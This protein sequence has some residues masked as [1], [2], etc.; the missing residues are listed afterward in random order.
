MVELIYLISLLLKEQSKNSVFNFFKMWQVLDFKSNKT[1]KLKFF[2]LLVAFTTCY[3]GEVNAQASRGG[4]FDFA[5]QVVENDYAG[6][7][8]KVTDKNRAEYEKLKTSL[9][10]AI[11]KGKDED[12][13]IGRYISWFNDGH[14]HYPTSSVNKGKSYNYTSDM[15]SKK[16]DVHT[17]MIRVP[18]FDA[19]K[20]SA[21][22]EMVEQYKKS[23]CEN[24]V[25]DIRS[26]GGGQ[27][28]T[29]D[30]LLALIYTHKGVV[31]GVEWLSTKNNINS[32]KNI[33]SKI[34]DERVRKYYNR[35]CERLELHVGEFVDNSQSTQEIVCDEIP[36]LPR[37]VAIVIDGNVVS[38]G[39][40]FVLNAK[41][42]S[43][44]VTVYGKDNTMGVL[45]FSN[46]VQVN[47]PNS[48][49][50]LY[51][52][53]SRS[54]RLPDRGIDEK[55][56]APDVRIT[57][58]NPKTVGSEIDPWITWISNDMMTGKSE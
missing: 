25:I 3:L 29:F 35:I 34:D 30:S 42:C 45:D 1:M 50:T 47:L 23:G 51:Y 21:I 19:D 52:P 22:I 32:F 31:D 15:I 6:Y 48:K 8:S 43:D 24:L 41:A 7:S 17:F 12:N 36:D 54:K 14:L 37:K 20:K 9:R 27:D 26:N 33:V 38:S 55:G 28:S 4:D 39:E 46:K 10:E 18:D 58:P 53:I 40:Q 57:L 5:V 13:C 44:K 56:I 11:S 2:S 16:V 49:M